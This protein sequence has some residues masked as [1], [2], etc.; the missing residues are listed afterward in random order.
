MSLQFCSAYWDISYIT[1]C[2]NVA[3]LLAE[4]TENNLQTPSHLES[5][6][7]EQPYSNTSLLQQAGL[8]RAFWQAL[9]IFKTL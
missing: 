4:T 9:K 2:S 3:Q 8:K 5:T 7:A 6:D 1:F